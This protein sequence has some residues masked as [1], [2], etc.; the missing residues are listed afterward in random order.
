M[1]IFRFNP[2]HKGDPDWMQIDDYL[3]SAWVGTWSVKVREVLDELGHRE[4]VALDGRVQA[5][6]RGVGVAQTQGSDNGRFGPVLDFDRN[7]NAG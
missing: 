7:R 6:Q 2:Q 5:A 3:E 4:V 1:S